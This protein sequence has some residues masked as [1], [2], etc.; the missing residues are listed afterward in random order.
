MRFFLL[1]RNLLVS[2]YYETINNLLFV[3]NDTLKDSDKADL[4]LFGNFDRSS[5]NEILRDFDLVKDCGLVES[6]D[7]VAGDLYD[8]VSV[9]RPIMADTVVAKE[10]IAVARQFVSSIPFVELSVSEFMRRV[11]RLKTAI[12]LGYLDEFDF[13]SRAERVQLRERFKD[14]LYYV[15]DLTT[16]KIYSFFYD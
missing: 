9:F 7:S 8:G 5:G 12:V 13:F 3:R 14:V 16:L 10:R 6:T 11:E 2:Q 4:A 15:E 1:Q